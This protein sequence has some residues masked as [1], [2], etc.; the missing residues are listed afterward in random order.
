MRE[1][2]VDQGHGLVLGIADLPG[3]PQR[4]LQ[5]AERGLRLFVVEV[6]DAAGAV[7]LH[8]GLGVA[9]GAGERQGGGQGLGGLLVLV[10]PSLLDGGQAQAL[11]LP[12]GVAELP[13]D[14][15]RPPGEL[16]RRLGLVVH[17]AQEGEAVE[18]FG[19]AAAVAELAPRSS[20]ARV[21]RS[22]S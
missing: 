22:I 7:D 10:E 2:E 17:A 21:R 6:E 4:A 11:G 12:G 14:L 15:R 20:R 5:M 13:P 9:G 18:R 3:E 16:A 1:A 8:A 19:F